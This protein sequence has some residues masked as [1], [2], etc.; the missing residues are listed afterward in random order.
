MR[1]KYPS[2][3]GKERPMPIPEDSLK[4]IFN[5]SKPEESLKKILNPHLSTYQLFT[6]S[7]FELCYNVNMFY[8]FVYFLSLWT[9]YY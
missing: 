8:F 2:D 1:E 7:V 3:R 4:E 9:G 5:K 6:A